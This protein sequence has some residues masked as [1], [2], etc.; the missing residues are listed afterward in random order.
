MDTIDAETIKKQ[1][2]MWE[3][4]TEAQRRYMEAQGK[5]SAARLEELRQVAEF[6]TAAAS[7]YHLDSMSSTK[8]P[9]H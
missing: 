5:T 8:Q 1:L 4:A 7:S 9:R 3:A 2:E 6:L